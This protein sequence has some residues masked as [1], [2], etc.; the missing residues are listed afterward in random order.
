MSLHASQIPPG[1]T[2]I[3]SHEDS[4]E[5]FLNVGPQHPSTHG[6]LRLVLRLDGETVREVVPHMGYIHRGIEKMG[7]K[8][9]F[10]QYIHLTDRM[11][12][13]CSHMNNLGVCLAIEKAM[14]IGVP[15]RGE[16]IRVIVNE[17]QR[18]QSHLLF[19]SAFGGDLGALS[20]FLYGFKVREV[21][22]DIFDEMCGAR[23]TMNFFRPGGSA[24]DV[25]ASVFA[26]IADFLPELDRAMAEFDRLVSGNAI[27]LRRSKGIGVLS[28]ANAL[29]YGC[30]GPVLR[31]SG[32]AYDVR[33]ARPYSIYDRFDFAV[34]TATEG[35]CYAR[36]AVRM[37]E[38]RQSSRIIKQALKE[39]PDGPHRSKEKPLYKLPAGTYY[40]EV[41]T[42]KGVFG[43]FI[44]SDG[45][46]KPYRIHNRT[47]NFCNLSVFNEL[48]VGHKI[49]DV[50]AILATLDVVIP[51]IDR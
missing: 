14:D 6:V 35:D 20:A 3:A 7:E 28:P 49:A 21:I 10:I 38:M 17:L 30:T 48:C 25:S 26:R 44:T 11:D 36:Y 19:W 15:E 33:R 9:S 45:T 51:D 8:Q 1:F 12:Y 13:I 47:P 34:P 43:T 2:R 42:A 40:S 31:G 39:L 37:E 29:A 5:F 32:I 22:T 41:E 23:L 50:I 16:Y 27:I 4:E 46:P 24:H 18:I